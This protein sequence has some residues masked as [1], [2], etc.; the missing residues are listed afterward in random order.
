MTSR[1]YARDL[2][3][4]LHILTDKVRWFTEESVRRA[5]EVIDAERSQQSEPEKKAPTKRPPK[6]RE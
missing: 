4:L 6:P 3:D 5:H 2:T 1:D